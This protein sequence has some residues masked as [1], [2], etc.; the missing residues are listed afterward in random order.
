MK[1]SIITVNL[2]NACGLED[3]INSVVNQT[4]HDYEF[5]IIDGGSID[6]SKPIIEQYKNQI[7]YWVSEPDKGIFNAM[8]KGIKASN[9][10]YLIFM[11]SGDVFYNKKVLEESQNYLGADFIIGK[12]KRKDNQETLNYELSNISM[13][14]FY[15]GAIPHQATFHKRSLFQHTLY[16]ENLKISSDWKFFFQKIILENASYTLMPVVVSFFDTTG[17]SNT[18]TDLATKERD[19]IISENLPTRIIQD[20][21]RYKD[22]ECEMLDLIPQFKYTR[23]INKIITGF[24]KMVLYFSKAKVTKT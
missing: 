2:N 15:K 9:G 5:L 11:N 22:K 17:I 8:N 4:C 24:T 3:T 1:Y 10:D 23:T 18:N 20:Y 16:D 19:R 13:M 12:I 6:N 21:E 7:D 14:T